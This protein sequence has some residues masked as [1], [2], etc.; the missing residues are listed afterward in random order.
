[1]ACAS[2]QKK[3]EHKE[4]RKD[5]K[6]KKEHKERKSDD[7]PKKEKKADCGCNR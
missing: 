6:K 3:K 7:K 4:K 5:H 1:M 2:C